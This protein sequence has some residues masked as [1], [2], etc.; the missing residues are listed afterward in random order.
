VQTLR[1]NNMTKITTILFLIL[2]TL[3]LFSQVAVI[4]DKD[5]FTNV[6]ENPDGKS[7][8]IYK[9]QDFELFLYETESTD[10]NDWIKVFLPKNKYSLDCKGFTI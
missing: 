6:R 1:L 5:G 7:K 9:I 3:R 10:N 8:V 4:D 2:F